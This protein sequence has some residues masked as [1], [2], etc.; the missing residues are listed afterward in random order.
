VAEHFPVFRHV[1]FLFLD[2]ARCGRSPR[3]RS[4]MKTLDPT[5]ARQLPAALIAVGR[6]WFAWRKLE[7]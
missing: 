1:G 3:K 2:N 7:R 4:P 5:M 6:G